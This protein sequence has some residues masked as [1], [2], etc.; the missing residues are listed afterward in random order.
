MNT[1]FK[2][3]MLLVV[4]IL[5]LIASSTVLAAPVGQTADLL[6]EIRVAAIEESTPIWQDDFETLLVEGFW[7]EETT[8]N[9][10]RFFADGTY[11]IAVFE[12][13]TVSWSMAGGTDPLM[14]EDFLVAVEAQR[15]AGAVD[16]EIGIVFHHLDSENFYVYSISSDGY[17]SLNRLAGGEWDYLVE[18]TVSEAIDTTEGAWNRLGLLVEQGEVTLLV[19]GIV[20]TT[21][22]DEAQ[23]SLGGIGLLAGAYEDEGVQIAFDNFKVWDLQNLFVLEP[24]PTVTPTPATITAAEPDPSL[25]AWIEEMRSST[26][27]W[28]EEFRRD[29]NTWEVD[30]S[31]TSQRFYHRGAYHVRAESDN[32]VTWGGPLDGQAF[33][34]FFVEVEAELI[35][36]PAYSEQGLLFRQVDD[37]NFYYFTV[38][39]EG[40][41]A[42]KKLIDGVWETVIDWQPSELITSGED[43]YNILGV[44][45]EGDQITLVVNDNLL[46]T[47]ED[48]TFASGRVALSVGT[49][50]EGGVEV[51][52]DNLVL[53]E[54]TAPTPATPAPTPTPTRRAPETTPTPQ[55]DPAASM[56]QIAAIHSTDP[57][58]SDDFRRSERGWGTTSTAE[59]VIEI[60]DRALSIRVN[61]LNWLAW[62]LNQ[63]IREV[64]PENFLVEIDAEH[65]AGPVD[66]GYGLVFGF[67]DAQNYYRFLITQ[68]GYA[69]LQ[70]FVDGVGTDLVPWAETALVR[71]EAGS[72]NRLGLLV[73]DDQITLFVNGEYLATVTDAAAYGGA[74]GVIGATGDV[75]GLEIVFDNFDLWTLPTA[76]GS[77][78]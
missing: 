65:V 72:T 62:T 21:I 40:Y 51:A 56:E 75:G 73:D 38:G 66:A 37:S 23:G 27:A 17:Y 24:G 52:F 77:D 11:Q 8:E 20:L 48:A 44:L 2:Q 9:S 49:F 47:V 6:T 67:Q 32:L 30:E 42:L 26:P 69:T 41:Y 19:N 7:S 61:S 64:V 31:D 39:N 3:P 53:W 68:N 58:F 1:S 14:Y 70:Q 22:A 74:I 63:E 36:G 78:D 29:N 43:A 59:S 13:D 33:G 76:L 35:G 28:R 18:W 15:V 16:N 54:R 5:A 4:V 60:A 55:Y 45:A 57:F 10:E 50:E 34:D 25:T 46:A 71:S 12:P